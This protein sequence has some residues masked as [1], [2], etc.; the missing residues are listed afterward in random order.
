MSLNH[1]SCVVRNLHL[2]EDF[3]RLYFEEGHFGNEIQILLWANKIRDDKLRI[4]MQ[5][6]FKNN[7][8]ESL[9]NKFVVD[10]NQ[11]NSNIPRL[12]F[13]NYVCDWFIITPMLIINMIG[14][15]KTHNR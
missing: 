12:R 11:H 13:T 4:K 5:G 3:R 6:N 10:E 9:T 7:S 15:E 8:I 2:I 14:L 1:L